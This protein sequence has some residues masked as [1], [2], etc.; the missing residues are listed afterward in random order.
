MSASPLNAQLGLAVAYR[1]DG[2][3]PWGPNAASPRRPWKRLTAKTLLRMPLPYPGVSHAL[4]LACYSLHNAAKLPRTKARVQPNGPIHEALAGEVFPAKLTPWLTG[5]GSRRLEG[6]NI[7]HQN[8]EAMAYVGVRVEPPVRLGHEGTV[9]DLHCSLVFKET[10]QP[11]SC[12][13]CRR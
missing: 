8:R 13:P 11:Y 1:S 12:L 10:C 4:T 9:F 5:A 7:G 6:T 2:T 3:T